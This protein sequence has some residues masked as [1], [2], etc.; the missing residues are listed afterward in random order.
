MY[1]RP[2]LVLPG[3][4]CVPLEGEY[5]VEELRGEWY[6]LGHNSVVRFDSQREAVA[7]FSELTGARG[8]DVLA[9]RALAQ[10]LDLELDLEQDLDLALALGPDENSSFS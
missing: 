6:V 10:A 8:P 4:V 5:R 3:G 9:G 1:K 2:F 7:K